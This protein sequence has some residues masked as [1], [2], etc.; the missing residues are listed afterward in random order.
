MLSASVVVRPSASVNHQRRMVERTLGRL[1]RRDIWLKHE[2][3]W[4]VEAR[5]GDGDAEVWTHDYP[6]ETDA[7]AVIRAM[8]DRNGGP[9]EWRD[10][11]K[12][13]TTRRRS[14]RQPTPPTSPF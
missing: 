4:R 9:T 10:I 11:Q 13:T 2:H 12:L 1:A 3:L 8:I 14:H 5:T 6:T 7:R